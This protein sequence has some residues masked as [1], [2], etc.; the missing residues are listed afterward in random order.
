MSKSDRILF[1]AKFAGLHAF[2]TLF[3]ALAV[4]AAIFYFWYPY[5]YGEL[6]GGRDL[7]AMIFVV[8]VICGPLNC[9]HCHIPLVQQVV[10]KHDIAAEWLKSLNIFKH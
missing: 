9:P 10:K 3:I 7:F 2:C 6:S 4:A 8:D 1:A 5:P